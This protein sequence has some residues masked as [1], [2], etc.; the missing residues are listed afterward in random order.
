MTALLARPLGA[1]PP[2]PER[3]PLLRSLVGEYTGKR[4]DY[5]EKALV[6]GYE[7]NLHASEVSPR[8]RSLA[9]LALVLFN[10]NEFAYVY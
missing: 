3:K 4:F 9:E 2:K 7:E 1:S 8:V 5:Q 10:T 6:E